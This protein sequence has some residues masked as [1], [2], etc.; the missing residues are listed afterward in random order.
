MMLEKA[1]T[2]RVHL[3]RD[4]DATLGERLQAGE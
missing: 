2:L 3:V 1:E 4:S